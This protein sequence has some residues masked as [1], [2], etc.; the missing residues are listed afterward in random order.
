M[1]VERCVFLKKNIKINSNLLFDALM[2]Y[3]PLNINR[4]NSIIHDEKK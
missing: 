3:Q 4:F 2:I 1:F